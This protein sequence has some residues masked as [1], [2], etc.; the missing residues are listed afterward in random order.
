[1]IHLTPA[2]TGIASPEPLTF[3]FSAK[4]SAHASWCGG[5]PF[6]LDE[7]GWQSWWQRESEAEER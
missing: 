6:P 1:M 7:S 3:A 2:M 5:A 4:T